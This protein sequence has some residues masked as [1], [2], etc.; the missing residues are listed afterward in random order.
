MTDSKLRTIPIDPN[1]PMTH[2]VDLGSGET[3]KTV[4]RTDYQRMVGS[5]MYAM[6]S[7]RP[8]TAMAVRVLS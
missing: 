4:D 5:L 3:G 6:T 2:E 1:T 7:T 8:D